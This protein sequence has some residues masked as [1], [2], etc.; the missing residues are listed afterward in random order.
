MER[1]RSHFETKTDNDHHDGHNEQR[2]QAFAGQRG[3]DLA[4]VH[5]A[6]QT[7]NQTQPI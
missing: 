7:I 2:V 1:H 5:R 6:G 4:E 3:G